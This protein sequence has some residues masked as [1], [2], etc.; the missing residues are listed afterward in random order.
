MPVAVTVLLFKCTWEHFSQ[1]SK[2]HEAQLYALFE[3]SDG[4]NG[5]LWL[6]T[7]CGL[8]VADRLVSSA[9]NDDC[10]SSA[11]F[12]HVDSLVTVFLI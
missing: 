9:W 8:V 6:L 4:T 3:D 10:P 12:S 11:G 5:I 7:Q 1:R 2:S